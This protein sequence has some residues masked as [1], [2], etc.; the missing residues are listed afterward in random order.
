MPAAWPLATTTAWADLNA[1]T[2]DPLFPP[3]HTAPPPSPEVWFRHSPARSRTTALVDPRPISQ[4]T[5][6]QSYVLGGGG[7]VFRKQRG[8]SCTA[9]SE[10]PLCVWIQ[11]KKRSTHTWITKLGS[12]RGANTVVLLLCLRFFSRGFFSPL[13]STLK[14]PSPFLFRLINRAHKHPHFVLFC[15]GG[16][17]GKKSGIL[18]P[19]CAV[20]E[21][22]GFFALKEKSQSMVRQ[23]FRERRFWNEHRAHAK[24]ITLDLQTTDLQTFD[25]YNN[26]WKGIED[27]FGIRKKKNFAEGFSKQRIIAALWSWVCSVQCSKPDVMISSSQDYKGRMLDF[28]G[29]N[30][31][32]ESELLECQADYSC[33]F[34]ILWHTKFKFNH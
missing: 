24:S 11:G 22:N 8:S 15:G 6:S 17:G 1:S 14:L 19:Q 23:F 27:H 10:K 18:Q 29:E 26:A 13:L 7:W 4:C 25:Q 9:A 21:L 33:F 31:D 28:N 16:G 34:H 30:T 3:H 2:S 5:C 12:L 20:N 32:F